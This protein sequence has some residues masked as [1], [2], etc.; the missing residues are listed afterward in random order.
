MGE[1]GSGKTTTLL[2]SLRLRRPE[3]GPI[4]IAGREIGARDRG[5]GRQGR[6][7]HE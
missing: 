5:G 3:G 7:C 2:E 6:R 1:S 4:E